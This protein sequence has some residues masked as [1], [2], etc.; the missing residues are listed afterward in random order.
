V[1]VEAEFHGIWK[2]DDG[3]IIDI[4]PK[5]PSIDNILFLPDTNRKYEGFQVA[6]RKMKI[7]DNGVLDDYFECCDALFAIQNHGDRKFK[8]GIVLQNDEI[9]IIEFLVSMKYSL[10]R[11]IYEG[12]NRNSVC[13]CNSNLKYKRCCGFMLRKVIADLKL[14]YTF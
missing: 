1:F 12:N 13:F 2:S 4:T 3:R 10:H 9:K 6:N 14:Y 5:V 11:F 8:K 7:S